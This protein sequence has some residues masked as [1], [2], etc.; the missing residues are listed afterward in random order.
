ML[1]GFYIMVIIIALYVCWRFIDYFSFRK[2]DD[3]DSLVLQYAEVWTVLLVPAIFL[4]VGD[5]NQKNDCCGQ[6]AVFS[7]DHS[8]GIY[9]LIIAY[10]AAYLISMNRTTIFT[11]LLEVLLNLLLMLG[12][13][14]NTALCFHLD[15]NSFMFGPLLWIF[16]NVPIMMLLLMKLSKHE[17]MLRRYIQ[18]HDLEVNGIPDRL[19]KFFLTLEPAVKYPVLALM[20]VPLSVLFSLVLVL[21]GQKPDSLIRAFTETYR[22]GFSELDHLCSNVVCGGHFLCSVGANGH[23]SVVK[24]IRYGVRKGSK[25]ICTRQLLVA[26]AFEESLGYRIRVR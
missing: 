15:T 19:S 24:P 1:E 13:A 25:I 5:V 18:K 8:V 2:D 17:D 22:H 9:V 3:R 14:I 4:F 16:G 10:K 23:R 12:L 6:S 20:L 11:P 7:P 26:N 21:F